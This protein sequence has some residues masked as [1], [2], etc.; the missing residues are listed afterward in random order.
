MPVNVA[1]FGKISVPSPN[2]ASGAEAFT[3]K[4][5]ATKALINAVIAAQ[6]PAATPAPLRS[7]DKNEPRTNANASMA[8]E[9]TRP[10][11]RPTK[12]PRQEGRLPAVV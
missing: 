12:I 9:T 2:M 5:P 8:I 10:I 4:K 11:N 6:M 1:S 7:N 3:A